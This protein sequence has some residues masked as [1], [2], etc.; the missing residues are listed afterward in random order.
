MSFRGA[1]RRALATPQGAS[2]T[3][4]FP[5][6]HVTVLV[7]DARLASHDEVALAEVAEA[8]TRVGLPRGRM[9]TLLSGTQP[10]DAARRERAREMHDM[11]GMP[12]V[13]HDPI[14][15]AGF[16][17]GTTRHG[18]LVQLDDELREAEA[19]VLIGEFANDHVRGAHGG[20]FALLPGLASADTRARLEARQ[21][22]AGPGNAYAVLKEAAGEMLALV[23]VDLALVWDESD[24]PIVRA[25]GG[26]LLEGLFAQGW[27]DPKR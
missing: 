18:L 15:G 6:P 26:D 17:V 7:G 21:Q 13:L 23:Q 10:I 19:V 8:L 1:V 12:V 3:Q 16:T 2:L 20:P 14:H 5:A 4:R 24:P 22:E 25:G 27:G 9:M 11:L